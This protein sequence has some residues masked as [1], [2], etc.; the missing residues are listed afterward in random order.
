MSNRPGSRFVNLTGQRFGKLTV[1][2]Q[3]NKSDDERVN[4]LC[5]C[6]CGGTIVTRA[7]NLTQGDTKSCGCLKKEQ[8]NKNLR[9]SYD[10]ERVDGVVKSLFTDQ[11]RKDSSTGYRGVST[12]KTRVGKELRYRAWITVD[13]K[14]YYK[15]GFKTAED[16]YY[17]GRLELERKHLPWGKK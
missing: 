11:P 3:V 16:A 5:Q 14:R 2:K 1:T 8:D 6:D 13:G 10:N 15:S 4:W 7:I 17:K 9:E 12:Y